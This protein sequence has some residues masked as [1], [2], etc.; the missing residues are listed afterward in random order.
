MSALPPT[1]VPGFHAEDDVKKIPYKMFGKT[2]MVVSAMSF[3]CAYISYGV[4]F[5]DDNETPVEGTEQL[6]AALDLIES[7]A[8]SGINYFDTAPFYGAGKSEIVLGL[9]LKRLPRQSF[10]IATKVG[11]NEKCCFDYSAKEIRRLV[12]NSL[13]KLHVEYIDLIQVH[14]PEF[15][16]DLTIILEETLP[17]LERLKKE[18]KVR[19]I[20]VN[21]Y[22]LE[23][24]K[25]IVEKSTV[26]IDSVLSYCRRTLFD[27]RL[28][29]FLPFFRQKNL[30]VIN[31]AV[32]GMGLLTPVDIPSWHAAND[33]VKQCCQEAKQYCTDNGFD[34]AR[35]A[36]GSGLMDTEV[37]TVL[38]GM[39]TKEILNWNLSVLTEGLTEAEKTAL[40]HSQ[41]KIMKKIKGGDWEGVDLEKY[42]SDPKAFCD[43][44][45]VAHG[46][47]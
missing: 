28:E 37:D 17:E 35:L 22:P 25:E 11:R 47:A 26:A 5:K 41:E 9:A 4:P 14:D 6:N 39:R 27:N 44:L 3:G 43:A 32:H 23:P 8:K 2:N 34:I 36:L 19:Y 1:F 30:A 46:S 31:A 24:L 38:T 10:Y 13:K 7:A 21:A 45:L 33:E 18:G 12:E 15:V 40:K 42:R 29:Q 20:G 16:D